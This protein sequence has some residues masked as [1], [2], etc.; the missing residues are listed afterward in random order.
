MLDTAANAS[1]FWYWPVSRLRFGP[2]LGAQAEAELE[3]PGGTTDT[4]SYVGSQSADTIK[5]GFKLQ[6]WP[7]FD[8]RVGKFGNRPGKQMQNGAPPRAA[9]Q[10]VGDR[11]GLFRSSTLLGRIRNFIEPF[12]MGVSACRSL[13]LRLEPYP[14]QNARRKSA[15]RRHFDRRQGH[16]AAF[17]EFGFARP[18]EFRTGLLNLL[19]QFQSPK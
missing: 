5:F 15:R 1:D 6:D 9:S 10:S 4:I 11:R 14:R 8:L 18:S 3:M 12:G 17:G 13:H 7:V 16:R 19:A 2:S